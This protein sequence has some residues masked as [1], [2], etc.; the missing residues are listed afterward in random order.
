MGRSRVIRVDKEFDDLLVDLQADCDFGLT[1]TQI[2]KRF[3][4]N[5]KKNGDEYFGI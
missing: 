5:Y 3:A 4:R 2:T 1:K